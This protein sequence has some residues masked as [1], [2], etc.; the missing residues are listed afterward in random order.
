M[1]ER[2]YDIGKLIKSGR[3]L[4]IYG[5]RC[6]GKTTLLES[7]LQHTKLK[8]KLDSGDNIRTREILSSSEF[9]R[10]LEYISGY[11]LLAIDEAQQIREVGAGLKII[12]DQA[13]NIK[14]VVTGSSSF[15][16]SQKIGEPL[17]GRKETVI[18]YP[19]SQ[20]E[21]LKS[22]NRHELRERLGEFLVFGS[23]PAVASAKGKRDKAKILTEIADSY[24]LKDILTLE[25]VKSSKVLLSLL[26]L[27]AFQVGQLVSMNELAG[28]LAIDI[29]TVGRYLDLLEKSFIIKA[30]G[31]FS[32]N[33]RKEISKKN[34]Y[35]FLDNGIRN[36]VILQFND[37]ADRNDIGA[38]WENFIFTERLKKRAY[39][40]IYGYVYFWRTYQGD[41]IDLVEERDGKLYGYE[42]KW[43]K[44]NVKVPAR[45]TGTE[46]KI[47][48]RDNYLD[49]I[50]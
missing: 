4:V 36:A 9:P 22:H 7:F 35:Y 49:F 1:I 38:L 33:L 11:E 8:Y 20:K 28:Q 25:K 29:K 32:R 24:L 18:L 6:V 10:I 39:E 2:Y 16:L 44:T 14:V 5:P 26:K 17:T 41:E 46:F 13:K 23:Y 37:I 27:L 3:V 31:G 50:T 48:N 45:W 12:V 42:I 40:S 21:L 30:V 47:I 19:I 34:K 15:E 43:G